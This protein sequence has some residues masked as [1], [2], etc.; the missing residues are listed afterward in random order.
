MRFFILLQSCLLSVE[1]FGFVPGIHN[2]YRH[3]QYDHSVHPVIV[4]RNH[5]Q[6]LSYSKS[7]FSL[8][9]TQDDVDL[10]I[11]GIDDID[12]DEDCNIKGMFGT[13]TVF[14]VS[15]NMG[16]LVKTALQSSLAQ[17]DS[18]DDRFTY[19]I[20]GDGESDKSN[21]PS[22]E[23]SSSPC[24]V[25]T[26]MFTFI[27]HE[28]TL[29]S[30]I[31]S[32]ADT[33]AMIM[34]TMANAKLRKKTLDMCQE[35]NV[36]VVDLLGPSLTHLSMYLQ[37]EPAGL[38]Q[39]ALRKDRLALSDKYYR[40]IEA[41]EF[42]LQADD[43]QA[44]W[45]LKDADII[46]VGVSRTGKTPLSVI[47]SQTQGLKVANIPLVLE[48]PVPQELLESTIDPERVFCLTISPNVL[49]QIRRTRLERRK[50]SAME[51]DLLLDDAEKKSNYGDRAYVL[52]DLKNARD[53]ALK[54]G[55]TEVDVTG[56]AVEESASYICEL[57]NERF[58]K[59]NFYN[60]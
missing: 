52:K 24:N 19:A 15:D 60:C 13:R 27:Q 59:Q 9:S 55:W 43:G 33:K 31:K 17:F 54:Q 6:F 2:I 35:L 46:I 18:C 38:P 28:E 30:I 40:R 47:L 42:T 32:A 23:N 41:V 12:D 16:N 7:P 29:T 57:L 48:C 10:S 5:I 44:P 21:D 25:Q 3:Q 51:K 22:D 53:L 20:T 49:K 1:T 45:L 14:L 34:F 39:S 26:R 4:T 56:R 37:K 11:D 50:V 8:K 36:Q 58:G